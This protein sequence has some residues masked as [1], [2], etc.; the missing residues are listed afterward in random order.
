MSFIYTP[1]PIN[2]QINP[3]TGIKDKRDGAQLYSPK[4]PPF[5][6]SL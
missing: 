4:V 6:K 5:L 2:K 3:T 1:K